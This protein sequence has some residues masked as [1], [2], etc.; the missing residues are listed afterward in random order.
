VLWV[1]GLAIRL[2]IPGPL[3]RRHWPVLA[4]CYL[5]KNPKHCASPVSRQRRPNQRTGLGHDGIPATE[6]AR[7]APHGPVSA[8]SASRLYFQR[9]HE[10]DIENTFDELKNQ[11]GWGGFTTHDLKR[12]RLLAGIVA[13]IFNWWSLFVRLAD[14]DHRPEAITSRPL[15]MQ[16]IARQTQHAGQVTLT[17]NS[18]HGERHKARRAYQ[19][20]AH[21]LAGL[22]STAEQ[23][24]AV[25]RWYRILSEALKRYL[26]GRRLEP[27]PRLA[28]A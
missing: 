15:L 27:P 8:A 19:R 23:L 25:Q 9:H 4:K 5:G 10:W 16:A 12:C 1:G 24:D 14:L 22:R 20:I 26:K 11:W 17:I 2:V 6:P 28:P 18:M 3:G 13:L 21:F 7:A